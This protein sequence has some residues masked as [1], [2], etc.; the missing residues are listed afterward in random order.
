MAQLEMSDVSEKARP[1]KANKNVKLFAVGFGGFLVAVLILFFGIGI[2]RAYAKTATDIWTVTA[3]K[4]LRLPAASVNG[5]RILYSDYVDDLH[6]IG[7]LREYT[8]S[9]GGGAAASFTDEQMSDQ[10][11]FRL[12]N[13]VLLQN[14]ARKYS[15]TVDDKDVDQLKTQIMQQFKT[16]GDIDSELEKRYGW[17]FATYERKVMR[18]FLLQSKLSDK[19]QTDETKRQAIREKA[20]VVLKQ[21]KAGAD[22]A[23]L[24][25]QYGSDGTAAKGGDLGWFKKG[26]MVPQFEAAAF[27]LKKGELSPDLVE[28]PYGYHIIRVDDRRVTTAKDAQ[29]KSTTQEEVKA[30]HILFSFPSVN[31]ELDTILKQALVKVYLKVHNPF[32]SL[33]TK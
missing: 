31:D 17:N 4:I 30:R 23:Q 24:A 20:E 32:T 26:D 2:Y 5:Q 16:T 1:A 3:A 29:G 7:V 13:N 9:N 27:A 25:E 11:L 8:K 28:S 19:I 18:P 22:F 15:V 33:N 12:V 14:E 21:L 10:V 6:A